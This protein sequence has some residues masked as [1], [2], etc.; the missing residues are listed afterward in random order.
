MAHPV[1]CV[2]CPMLG[3]MLHYYYSDLFISTFFFQNIPFRITRNL[4]E[5]FGTSKSLVCHQT[6]MFIY[7]NNFLVKCLK[8]SSCRKI[9]PQISWASM[10]KTWHFE[11]PKALL[12]C[13]SLFLKEIF[14]ECFFLE[15]PQSILIIQALKARKYHQNKQT[16]KR[17]Q[18]TETYD[19]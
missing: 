1:L 7:T 16:V 10:T 11:I 8:T 2:E 15:K 18:W 3:I 19:T 4:L 12:L 17:W 6:K 9:I 13:F 5:F 14:A